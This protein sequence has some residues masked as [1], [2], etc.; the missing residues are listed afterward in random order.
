ARRGPQR[1]AQH[2][3]PGRLPDLGA[4]VPPF[5]CGPGQATNPII[6]IMTLQTL[7][8]R[9]TLWIVLGS[10]AGALVCI[11]I[12]AA[13]CGQTIPS[14]GKTGKK[15][16]KVAPDLQPLEVAADLLEKKADLPRCKEALHMV[17]TYLGRHPDGKAK[18]ARLAARREQLE[19]IAVRAA[20]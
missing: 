11:L 19:K 10:V 17:N 14:G 13:G 15:G 9:R 6:K 16:V 20:D 5:A 2:D 8:S 12:F 3:R 18:I 1:R 7:I 4:G